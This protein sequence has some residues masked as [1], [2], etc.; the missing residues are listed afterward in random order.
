MFPG[1]APVK[2]QQ[3]RS[4]GGSGSSHPDRVKK[5]IVG[6]FSFIAKLFKRYKIS[7]QL[8]LEKPVRKFLTGFFTSLYIESERQQCK[9]K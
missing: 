1:S 2:T 3:C 5:M 6:I 8:Q 7:R 9:C 4:G